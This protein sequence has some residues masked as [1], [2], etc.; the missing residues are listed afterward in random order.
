MD[1]K[2]WHLSL[3]LFIVAFATAVALFLIS[4]P[5]QAQECPPPGGVCLTSEQRRSLIK[6]VEELRDIH[7]SKADLKLLDPIVIIRDREGRVYV[8]G[9]CA[10]PLRMRLKIGRHV[11]RDLAVTLP[12]R[13]WYEKDPPDPMFRLRLRAQ[14]GFAI[15]ALLDSLDESEGKISDGLDAGIGWDFFHLNVFNLSAY[16]GVKSV[17]VL[18]GADLTKNFGTSLGPALTYRGFDPNLLLGAYFSFN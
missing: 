17:G 16:T 15:P 5:A 9:G 10:R 8:R 18:I 13:V 12:V 1:M 4:G 6:A 3:L 14:A 11:D 7:A 2:L